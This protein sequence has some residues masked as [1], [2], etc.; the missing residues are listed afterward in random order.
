MKLYYHPASTTCRPI[1]LFAEESRFAL[2]YQLVDIFTGEQYQ[3]AYTSINPCHMVPVLEDGDFR[4]TE[5]SAILKYLADKID[6]PAYPKD[7]QAR[8][9]VNERMDFVNTQVS[10]EFTYSFVYPQLLPIFKRKDEAVQ[11]A[12]LEWGRER[13][14][15]WLTVLDQHFIGRHRYLCGDAITIADYF[16]VA[17]VALGE[18]IRCDFSP[19]PNIKRWLGNMHEL[20]SWRKVNEAIDGFAASLKDTQFEPL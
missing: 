2:D 1:M 9:R 3:D 16:A 10:R 20:R 11:A 13:S 17:F 4:L 7:L 12:T 19:Y 14:R 6:S 15:G 8:A 5:S 18:A